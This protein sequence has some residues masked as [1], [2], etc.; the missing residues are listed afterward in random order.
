MYLQ[1]YNYKT[2]F[3][4]CD[5]LCL[6]RWHLADLCLRPQVG[7]ISDRRIHLQR[8]PDA[9]PQRTLLLWGFHERVSVQ[10]LQHFNNIKYNKLHFYFNKHRPHFIAT[11][12][13]IYMDVYIYIYIYIFVLMWICM[14]VFLFRRLMSLKEN[15]TTGEW[16]YTE[17]C[18][19][20]DQTCRFPKLINSYYKYIIS[21]AEDEA[22]NDCVWLAT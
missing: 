12:D 22:G 15:V 17:I 2:M 11:L 4:L 10:Y 5:V 20:T 1:Y 13:W 3:F 21:F 8:L 19:G 6:C 9:Q 7:K 18:M 16:H 14:H